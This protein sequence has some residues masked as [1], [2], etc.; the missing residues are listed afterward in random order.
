MNLKGLFLHFM[1]VLTAK[2]N[3]LRVLCFVCR[4]S[5]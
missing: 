1:E 3:E 4:V 2:K 5:C